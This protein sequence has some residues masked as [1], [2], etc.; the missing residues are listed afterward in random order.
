MVCKLY[1][2]YQMHGVIILK[3]T[4]LLLLRIMRCAVRIFDKYYCSNNFVM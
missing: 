2:L 4:Y 1:W 3:I